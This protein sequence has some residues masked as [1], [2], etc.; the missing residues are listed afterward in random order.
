MA[1]SASPR[2]WSPAPSRINGPVSPKSW[3]AEIER[4]R[5]LL[6]R[7]AGAECYESTAAMLRL[8]AAAIEAYDGAKIAR[9][10]LDFEDLVVKT[11]RLLAGANASEWVHYKLDRGLDHILVDEAQDTSPRQWQ[12]VKAL[13]EEFFAGRGAAETTRTLFAVGDEKQS[14][15]SFQGAVPAWFARMRAEFG[16]RARAAGLKW[17]DPQLHISFRSVQKVLA[18]VDAVFGRGT[19]HAALSEAGIAPVHS[20]ARTRDSG[21]V[22]I[23]PMIE[24][25]A[26]AEPADWTTPLDHLGEQSP[27][28]RLANRIAKT[29]VGWLQSGE[30]LDTG[31]PIRAGGILVLARTRGAQTDAINRA[32]KSHGIPIAGADRLALTEHIAVMDLIAL[33][34]VM[35][36]PE[37]DLSLAAV[38][39]SPLIGLGEDE[40][41]ALAWNRPGSLW[42][43]LGSATD[44]NLVAARA[45]LE[46]W[47]ATAD[48]LDPHAFF[49][50][51]LGPEQGRRRLLMRLGAEAEDVL[52]EFLAQALAH[53]RSAVP[54]LEGFLHWLDAAE[55]EI[56]R[57]T[58][59]LRDEVRVMTVHG[60][61]GLE[62]D[63]VFLV[64]TGAMPVHPSHDAKV[65]ALD[66][67][68]D[69]RP[70]PLVWMRRVKAM[71]KPVEARIQALR[72]EARRE[73]V[74]LLYV[75]MTRARDRLIVCGTLKQR[76]T[77]LADG[78]HALVRPA[79][80]PE[81]TRRRG[82]GR[83]AAGPRV[84]AGASAAD[85]DRAAAADA[86]LRTATAGLAGEARPAAAT[87]ASARL[88]VG[89]ACRDGEAFPARP[90]ARLDRES[91]LALE[92][93]RL[94]P[95]PPPVAARDR[96][97]GTP[98]HRRTLPRRDRERMARGRPR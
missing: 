7:L 5:A 1:I 68:A 41:Y 25:A 3:K 48:H 77:D 74:R 95:P 76:G 81:C 70:G 84:A 60:A 38:L 20:A 47:R 89:G 8:A 61:K 80:E 63:V 64:D 59:T 56:K 46:A 23:W 34:R 85:E 91:A 2:A 19:V 71:P 98:H 73:Y 79:L 55:T 15:F 36:L 92:R 14:I 96:A 43:A 21:R 32:L 72:E 37:D 16:G 97:R 31:E 24:P 87:G 29:I 54:S 69:G 18:A 10:V 12:V 11:A 82:R 9:G 22:T 26:K 39:K 49:A 53:E 78:W 50:R 44:A 13:V 93:G 62:A 27:E 30:K 17:S 83:H 57:D 86:A 75:A 51:I 66:D 88:A 65:V 4:L 42:D 28:V 67:D 6:D 52:D 40:L 45:Q 33:G 90:I 94:D 58:E 35:L